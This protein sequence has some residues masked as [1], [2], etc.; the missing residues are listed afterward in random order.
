MKNPF[1]WFID[2]IMADAPQP[3][4]FIEAVGATIDD[5]DADWRPLSGDGKRDLSPMTQRRM[6]DLAVYLWESNLLAN[7][8]IE[9]PVAYI[10][11][12]GVRLK[13]EDEIIQEVLDNFWDHPINCMNIKLVKKVRELALYG[14]QCWPAFVNEFD[15]SVRL[16]Y[17]D[18]SLIET[19]VVDPDNG[20]Q[21]IGVVTCKN[22]KGES[23]RYRV[24]VNGSE[25]DLFTKRTIAIRETF[26]DGDCFYF[27]INDLSNGRRGRSDLL[28]QTD[29]LD[30]YDQFMFGELDRVQFMRAFMWDVTLAGA[31]EDDVKQKAASIRSPKPGSVRVHNDA[32]SW[33]AESPNIN[34]GDTDT[35][36][37]LVRN[38]ILGGATIPEHW[39]GGA[40]DVNRATGEDMS[41]PTFKVM[42]MRQAFIGYMLIEVG[43]F[44][45]RN[46]ELAH[47]RKEPDMSDPIYALEVSWPE[48][49]AKDT[50]KY[51]NALQQVT[52]ACGQAI[53]SK[54]LSR[55]TAIEV[56]ESVAGRL[57]VAFDAEEEL[58]AVDAQPPPN[59]DDLANIDNTGANTEPAP[60]GVKEAVF[61][62]TDKQK[63]D[64]PGEMTHLL[65]ITAQPAIDSM[66]DTVK[67]MLD[68]ADNLTEAMDNMDKL[69]PE[70]DDSQLA[71]ILSQAIL[72]ANLAGRE[73]INNGR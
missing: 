36:A 71:D 50:T 28:P 46:W 8:L 38:H 48:M 12:E 35:T 55:K 33:K 17:L 20:E 10:L 68:K 45:I 61:R 9:L 58:A 7:R 34:A 51:A 27:C 73:R 15:G 65:G 53:A 64:P 23:R 69:F 19:V 42:S 72:A 63:S 49:V 4:R 37:K 24:I 21:P 56:I 41:G 62:I 3:E 60:T 47:T 14:E 16:G 1:N 44:V 39:F 13:A 70:L 57:G 40:G 25:S 30:S 11:A 6:Q 54:L 22:K 31:N 29:W 66:L 59:P 26:S 43:K 67:A 2:L 52:Q 18:P 5:D 32:E